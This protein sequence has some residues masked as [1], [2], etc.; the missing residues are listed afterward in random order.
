[1]MSYIVLFCGEIHSVAEF[2][3]AL[4]VPL[5]YPNYF[6]PNLDALHD[7][8]SERN[9]TLELRDFEKLIDNLGGHAG[10]I[11][12]M[13]TDSDSEYSNFKLIIK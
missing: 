13:L 6:S 12:K 5:S 4:R 11:R 3:S 2:F 8:L 7:L 10:A 9:V 1:M